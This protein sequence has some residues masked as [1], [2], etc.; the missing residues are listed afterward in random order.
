M[1]ASK[2]SGRSLSI[3][4]VVVVAACV[5]AACGGEK[6]ATG[7]RSATSESGAATARRTA[8]PA[9]QAQIDS[10]LAS[11]DRVDGAADHVVSRCPGCQLHMQGSEAHA[12]QMGAYAMHF[13]SEDCKARFGKDVEKSVLALEIP[14]ETPTGE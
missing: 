9:T 3:A 14:A 6:P 13:C 2:I 10:I 11:A 8:D 12:V 7:E 1:S 5:A 4:C